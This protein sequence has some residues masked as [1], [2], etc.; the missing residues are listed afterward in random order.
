MS[1]EFAPDEQLFRERADAW[2]DVALVGGPTSRAFPYAI[3]FKEAA[4][5]L[6]DAVLA[7]RM[8]DL[9]LFPILYL[10]RHAIELAL[11]DLVYEDQRYDGLT[12]VVLI[13]HK[14]SVLWPRARQVMERIFPEGDTTEL[15][16][17][18][19]LIDELDAADP[20]GSSFRYDVDATGYVRELPDELRR[21]DILNVKAVC[22]KIFV[23]LSGTADMISEA[24]REA[25]YW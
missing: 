19:R 4:D 1:F 9:T 12:P 25:Q 10:Y 16:T 6:V 14:L 11:K 18:G 23:R 3:G 7:S 24:R 15:D 20:D 5:R 13:T 22:G 17:I 8:Q 21:V 2:R